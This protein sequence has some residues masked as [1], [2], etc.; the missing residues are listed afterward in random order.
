MGL[1]F[2]INMM[3]SVM[4][5]MEAVIEP[6]SSPTNVFECVLPSRSTKWPKKSAWSSGLAL[7]MSS[8]YMAGWVLL[9]TASALTGTVQDV[10]SKRC[11][12]YAEQE[13]VFLPFPGCRSPVRSVVGL[14]STLPY[15][16]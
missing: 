3:G 7:F 16:S 6:N 5:G 15:C 1:W 14:S 12:E 4:P 8:Q 9:S 2:P 11:D 13:M 10:I